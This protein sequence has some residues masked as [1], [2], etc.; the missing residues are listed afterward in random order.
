MTSNRRPKAHPP[1]NDSK[2]QAEREIPILLP[3][4]ERHR[5]YKVAVAM[6]M[7]RSKPDNVSADDYVR[8]LAEDMR[9]NEARL[10]DV[11]KSLED[12]VIHLR[13]KVAL[14]S[15]R[16]GIRSEAFAFR[17]ESWTNSTEK[18]SITAERIGQHWVFLQNYL[19]ITSNAA[20][21]NQADDI[22]TEELTLRSANNLLGT[23]RK[24]TPIGCVEMELC[25]KALSTL[26]DMCND[27]RNALAPSLRAAVMG[28]VTDSVNEIVER[29]EVVEYS[30]LENIAS[31]VGTL[32]SGQAVT[33]A[34]TRHLLDKF[35]QFASFI[36]TLQEDQRGQEADHFDRTYF[37]LKCTENV[38]ASLKQVSPLD[39]CELSEIATA[40]V[41]FSVKCQETHPL[42]ASYL[43]EVVS[44]LKKSLTRRKSSKQEVPKLVLVR[45]KL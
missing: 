10:S 42:F 3:Q 27:R 18:L 26:A 1:E 7:I 17:R 21:S 24:C 8:K 33:L 30:R 12:D 38:V 4:D 23:L 2:D 6:A 35:L 45:K 15:V 5:K 36:D 19:S 41:D 20:L 39:C 40:L 37:L 16:G 13:Q 43:Y 14:M 44:A 25:N 31:W 22:D 32:A 29:K 34:I 28:F 11:C 9:N